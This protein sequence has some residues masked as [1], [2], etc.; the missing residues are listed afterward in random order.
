MDSESRQQNNGSGTTKSTCP[1]ARMNL[2]SNSTAT[3][4]T[5]DDEPGRIVP[6]LSAIT[7]SDSTPV[8][9]A[10]QQLQLLQ[11]RCPAFQN[12]SCPFQKAQSV[13]E[14]RQTLSQMPSSHHHHLL[15]P[16]HSSDAAEYWARLVQEIHLIARS[17]TT[18]TTTTTTTASSSSNDDRQSASHSLPMQMSATTTTTATKNQKTWTFAEALE[19]MSL[20]AIMSQA[21]QHEEETGAADG[22]DDNDDA[23]AAITTTTT[24]VAATIQD[25]LER[26]H[27][28]QMETTLSN[29]HEIPDAITSTKKNTDQ[30]KIDH[31]IANTERTKST[32]QTH[33]ES[34]SELLKT[35]T[36]TAHQAA[37]DV[38][39]VADFI[40]GKINRHIYGLFVWDLYFVYQALE[41]CL[42]RYAPEYFPSCH[43]PQQLSRTAALEEDVDFWHG[44]VNLGTNHHL[45]NK[46]L[47]PATKDYVNRLYQLAEQN[48]LLLLAHSYTRYFG[49]LSGGRILARVARKALQLGSD[50]DQPHEGLQFYHFEAITSPKLFKDQ[51]RQ[52]LD[53]LPLSSDQMKALVAEANVAFVLNIR[54]FEE[55]DQQAGLPGATVRPLE[56]ALQYANSTSPSS[57]LSVA[58]QGGATPSTAKQECPFL[59][60]K[61]KNSNNT[62][63]PQ[64]E[65]DN[66]PVEKTKHPKRTTG[67]T[68]NGRCPWPFIFC[69]DFQQGMRDWQTWFLLGLIFC[70][71]WH[72]YH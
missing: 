47:S 22:D 41:D 50:P 16:G 63:N 9:P 44:A 55:L 45:P 51:F 1:F 64:S 65:T 19:C 39:F 15:I 67:S 52:A 62:L 10:Q 18:T 6:T 56:D 54:L 42:D 31:T 37:E 3:A 24:I 35:G 30:N 48:P 12:G 8:T 60:S 25:T 40:K 27:E 2:L 38:H 11:Q 7:N 5:P 59:V 32:S 71:M 23:N 68:T 49:D 36:A 29:A 61:E 17:V 43:F 21:V 72:W 14:I 57:S 13:E 66:R 34:L 28:S 70:T 53:A 4:M 33:N 58:V 26:V 20:A 46:H 69:H